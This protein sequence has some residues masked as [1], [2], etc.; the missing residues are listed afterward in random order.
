MFAELRAGCSCSCA[1][2]GLCLHPGT[3]CPAQFLQQ[4]CTLLLSK[5]YAAC[6]AASLRHR[7]QCRLGLGGRLPPRE[8]YPLAAQTP[9]CWGRP[10]SL[11]Q[12]AQRPSSR[13]RPSASQHQALQ[14]AEA[15]TAETRWQQRRWSWMRGR[16]AAALR[17]LST[18]ACLVRLC[19]AALCTLL[20]ACAPHLAVPAAKLLRN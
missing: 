6:P 19:A 11:S 9:P 10:H 7:Q 18:C 20:P 14:Q 5:R 8:P 1:A 17:R 4:S 3:S 13:G 15:S 16:A 12:P 2:Q